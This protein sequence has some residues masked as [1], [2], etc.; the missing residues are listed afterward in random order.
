MKKP[1]ACILRTAGTN[2]DRETAFAF[3]KAGAAIELL[4]INS[5]IRLRKRLRDYQIL[6][7]P[8]GFTYGDDI[9]AGKIL[10]NELRH[11]LTGDIKKFIQEGKIIIGICNGFQVLVKS[12]LLPGNNE[13]TQEASLVI[14]DSGKFE[15]RWVYLKKSQIP[16]PKSQNKCIWT[17]NLPEIIYLP[18]AHGEG[19]FITKDKAVLQRIRD[20]N[21]IV[22]QYC[23]EQGRSTG[24]P[25]NP[26][27]SQDN[28][29]GII[30]DSGRILGLMPHPERHIEAFQHP[31]KWQTAKKKSE[32]DGL[33][34]FRNGVE[35]IRKNF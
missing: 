29:A 19:K 14:N 1:K 23:D 8:G 21:Q 5:L 24:Y 10:A 18:V 9:A 2:C 3:H 33:Q 26:N 35:Y 30:D 31:R 28:I 20:N 27:G 11:K 32:G 15:D 6:A 13:L 34:I 17:K 25:Y 7:I 16:N 22:F 4:H 12:G